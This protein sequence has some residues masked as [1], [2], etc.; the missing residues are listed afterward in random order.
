LSGEKRQHATLVQALVR[1]IEFPRRPQF[2]AKRAEH[3][4]RDQLEKAGRIGAGCRNSTHGVK[5]RAR[6]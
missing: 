4:E 1:P 5:F 2:A 3:N 6:K